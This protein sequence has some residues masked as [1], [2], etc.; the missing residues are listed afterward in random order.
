MQPGRTRTQLQ[1]LR[2]PAR[3]SCPPAVSTE[4]AIEVTNLELSYGS[5]QALRKVTFSVS[6]GEIFGLLGPN[7]SGKTSLFRV[8]TTL[9]SPTA[10][11]ISV[12]GENLL[13]APGG[14]RRFAG[15]VFQSQSLDRKL[16]VTENLRHQGHLYGLR[17]PALRRRIADVLD[18]FGLSER[19]SDI[20]EFLSGGMK[21]RLELAKSILHRPLLLLLDEPSTGLD[22]GARREFWQYL[23]ALNRDD[24]TTVLVTT[25]LM[26]EAEKCHRLAVLNE[27]VLVA[28]DTPEA[29]KSRVGGDVIVLRTPHAQQLSLS[30]GSWFGLPV[31]VVDNTVRIERPKGHEFITD[32]VESFPGQIDAVTL[33]KPSLE[34]VFIHMTGHAFWESSH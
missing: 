31:A 33:S 30:I 5:V 14:V 1:R 9:S 18:Q 8:L 16:T 26:D 27:G 20:V 10:G 2:E 12:F 28:L 11:S 6:S 17:G 21:R 19:A 34:D 32:L 13:Q 25:H 22:P 23:E 4:P 15:V 29:L 3:S 7:G 24:R